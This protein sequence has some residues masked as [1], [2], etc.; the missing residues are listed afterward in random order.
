MARDAC[1]SAQRKSSAAAELNNRERRE[2]A[3]DR[4]FAATIGKRAGRMAKGAGAGVYDGEDDHL[5]RLL[6]K[7]DSIRKPAD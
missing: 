7:E 6:Y 4:P 5:V 2:Q 1:A 3:S